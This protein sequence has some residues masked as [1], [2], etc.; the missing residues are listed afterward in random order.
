MSRSA[1]TKARDM[2]ARIT[3]TS[4]RGISTPQ[5]ETAMLDLAGTHE[6]VQ[7]LESGRDGHGVL[8]R[9]ELDLEVAREHLN[10]G[11]SLSERL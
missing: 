10:Q 7:R 6:A 4:L 8:C 9:E 11:Q 2:I 3:S 5:I 1:A